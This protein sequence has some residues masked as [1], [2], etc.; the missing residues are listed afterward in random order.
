M[1]ENLIN[2]DIIVFFI[3]NYKKPIKIIDQNQLSEI[4]GTISRD[5]N[6]ILNN[7]N[8]RMEILNQ[9]T[10]FKFNFFHVLC[11]YGKPQDLIVA[12]EILQNDGNKFM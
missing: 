7:E 6:K 2:N 5:W 4:V 1:K 9:F 8:P 3:K 11:K 10:E 12:L